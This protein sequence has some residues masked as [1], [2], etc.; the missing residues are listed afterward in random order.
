MGSFSCGVRTPYLQYACGIEFPD[1][2]SN[3]SPLHWECGVL[4]SGP[5]GKSQKVTLALIELFWRF[6]SYRQL[7]FS[8]AFLFSYSLS[9]PL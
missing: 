3:P 5:P 1:Q 6:L 9:S 7:S 8:F 4:P 2:G